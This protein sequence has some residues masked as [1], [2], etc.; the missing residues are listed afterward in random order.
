MEKNPVKLPKKVAEFIQDYIDDIVEFN[1]TPEIE[2]QMNILKMRYHVIAEQY[3]KTVSIWLKST[4]N[5][6][7]FLNALF[8]GYEIDETDN[9]EKYEGRCFVS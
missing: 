2:W 7:T 8:Y 4:T 1:N 6:I 3:D 5:S 9:L